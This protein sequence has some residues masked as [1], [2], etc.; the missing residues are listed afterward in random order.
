M[1]KPPDGHATVAGLHVIEIQNRVNVFCPIL[2]LL[3]FVCWETIRNSIGFLVTETDA[4]NT[5]YVRI[6]C[7]KMRGTAKPRE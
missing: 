2:S 3:V 1:K 5:V 7:L 6:S 4:N